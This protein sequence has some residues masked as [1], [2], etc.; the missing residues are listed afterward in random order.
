MRYW[1]DC[2]FDGHNGDLI[3]LALVREDGDSLYIITSNHI[4]YDPWVRDNVLPIVHNHQSNKWIVVPIDE[5]G[6]VLKV[7]LDDDPTIIA[8]SPVDIYRLCRALSTDADGNW[9][10][11]NLEHITLIVDN[12]DAYPTT[13]EGVVQHNAYWDA[14]A[15]ME[16]RCE[17]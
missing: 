14:K 7:Y 2:E 10:S 4:V 8:D 1:L 15:L 12:I 11:C 5:V 3:S 6:A 9:A 13:L 16:K 17:S